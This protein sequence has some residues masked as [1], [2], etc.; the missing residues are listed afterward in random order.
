LLCVPK[1]ADLN[2]DLA[3][4]FDGDVDLL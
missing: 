4:L 2:P 3:A 1:C